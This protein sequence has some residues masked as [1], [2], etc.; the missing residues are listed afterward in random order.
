MLIQNISIHYTNFKKI[1]NLMD[2]L[3]QNKEES[4][5]SKDLSIQ[6][7]ATTVHEKDLSIQELATTVHEKDSQL[8]YWKGLAHSMRLKNR[9]KQFLR[10]ILPNKMLL[11]T[12]KVWKLIVLFRNE[13]MKGVASRIQ[14][15]RLSNKVGIE[16]GYQ[17]KTP[18]LTG[19]VKE[20]MDS[21]EVS[22]LISILLLLNKGKYESFSNLVQSL[23]SQWYMNWE[24]CIIGTEESSDAIIKWLNTS[25]KTNIKHRILDSCK[26]DEASLL[27]EA[28]DLAEGEF[29]THLECDAEITI[30]A[31]YEIVKSANQHKEAKVFYSDEDTKDNGQY[32]AP[33]FKPDFAPDSLLS[34]NYLNHLSVIEKEM[35][36]NIGGYHSDDVDYDLILRL[37]ELQ[38]EFVHVPKVLYHKCRMDKDSDCVTQERANKGLR[39]LQKAVA[40]RGIKAEILKGER[41]DTY[42]VKYE[43]KGEPLVSIVVPFKDKPE[44]LTMC[45]ESVIGKSTYCNF[46]LIGVSNNS[47]LDETFREM[48]RLEAL[49]ERI[50]F[51]EYNEPFNYSS[52]NN[53]AVQHYAEGEFVVFLN[54][55]IEVITPSWIENMLEHAQRSDV[56]GV[57]AKLYF[58]NDTIQHAGVIMGKGQWRNYGHGVAGHAYSHFKE[59]SS[60]VDYL[61]SL[62]VI[63]NYH[64]LTAAC[65]MVKRSLF[66]KLKGFNEKDLAVAFNDVDFCLRL[67]KLGLKNIYTPYA[68][69][70]HYES[71]SRGN[72][73]YD[74]EKQK[75]YTSE[76][77]YMFEHYLD[78]MQYDKYYNKNLSLIKDNS[79]RQD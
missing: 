53:Y 32:V 70:Y 52:I 12:R 73:A 50:K 5:A 17:Y 59:G 38:C 49:D 57:G 8:D 63:S 78:I 23:E 56:G 21:F 51:H 26:G 76:V 9:A 41:R 58:P 45:I 54:N 66:V 15:K 39:A 62:D 22:P 61:R 47:E 75:R 30:D 29:V 67:E 64:A 3:I 24:L 2:M 44:L 4:I 68:E 6:E 13:G 72:D 36:L 1:D 27:S 65:L 60:T 10:H 48:R 74:E 79:L 43:I 28:L 20:N 77:N 42:R 33:Y 14:E 35:V 11:V 25:G 71:V 19:V 55:D 46:E 31:F 7:L 69:L 18:V 16:T 34:Q 37:S 40:R